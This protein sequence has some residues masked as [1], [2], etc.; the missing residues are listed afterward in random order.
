LAA[1]VD[2]GAPVAATCASASSIVIENI[3]PSLTA[4]AEELNNQRAATAMHKKS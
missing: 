3:N 4:G 2:S 1:A